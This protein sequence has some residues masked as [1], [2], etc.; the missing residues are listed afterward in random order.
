MTY[1]LVSVALGGALGATF[2]YLVGL[3][4]MRDGFPLAV[5]TVNVIGSFVMGL[6]TVLLARMGLPHWQPFLLTGVLG[7]FTTFSAFSL[8]TLTLVERGQ[9]GMALLY[10][11]L[12]VCLSLLALAT[13]LFIARGLT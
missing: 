11:A 9:V 5:L 4:M 13:G 2:R 12:S 1:P 8:E 6:G 3:A 7:G 10:V